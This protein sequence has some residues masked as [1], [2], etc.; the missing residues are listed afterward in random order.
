MRGDSHTSHSNLGVAL[1][2]HELRN[3]LSGMAALGQQ[4][5]ISGLTP[6]QL[7]L[8]RAWRQSAGQILWLAEAL[9]RN[10]KAADLCEVSRPAS[11][12][13]VE[14][15]EQLVWCHTPAAL[16]QQQ[17]VLLDIASGVPA[18]WQCDARLLR[19]VLDNLLA[20]AVRYGGAGAIVLEV[21]CRA[22][23]GLEFRVRDP[24]PGIPVRD[25]T[26]MFEPWARGVSDSAGP[27]G[28]GLGLYLCRRIVSSLNGSLRYAAQGA[29]GS[30]FTLHLPA[31]IRPRD[32]LPA[33][34]PSQL[35]RSL[36]CVLALPDV[37]TSPVRDILERLG[38][39]R[40]ADSRD[41][42]SEGM[43]A[44]GI[45]EISEPL[46]GRDRRKSSQALLFRARTRAGGRSWSKQL[47]L[48]FL[49]STIGPVLMELALELRLSRT[50]AT[51]LDRPADAGPGS[52]P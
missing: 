35:F 44:H 25:R 15:L 11:V 4:L 24:G 9:G 37:L 12:H 19:T 38:V 48:P 39:C 27:G 13:G 51:R 52:V 5:E 1:I 7:S 28:A 45:V 2:S 31:V 8:L 43:P 21:R 26:R 3:V 16:D 33:P 36:V 41:A 23:T 20:N 17:V 49:E 40:V 42:E 50:P 18:G 22:E 47:T 29:R 30:C 6:Q 10:D 14:L 32:R 46:L 34:A